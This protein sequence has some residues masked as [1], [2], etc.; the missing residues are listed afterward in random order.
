MEPERERERERKRERERCL[1][2]S[3][4]VSNVIDRTKDQKT[5]QGDTIHDHKAH[6]VIAR[7]GGVRENKTPHGANGYVIITM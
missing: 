2:F 1:R 7:S 5:R 6:S 3:A 4:H